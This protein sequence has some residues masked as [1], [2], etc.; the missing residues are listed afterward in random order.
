MK[1][2]LTELVFILD[3]SGSMQGL[4]VDTIGGFNA[5][6]EKQKKEP[7]EAFVST[8]LFNDH[9]QV[10][11]DR[12]KIEAVEPITHRE[13]YVRGC[14]ALLDAI[15]GAIHH[16]GNIHKYARS[17]DVPEHTLFVITTD[18]MENAS[19]RYTSQ[20]VKT[21]IQ[22]QKEKYGW[23]FLFLGAN[24]DA[25]ETAGSLGIAPDRAVNYHCDSEGTRLN[26]EVVSQAVTAV[27][28]CA[29]LDE[30]WKDDIEEDFRKRKSNRR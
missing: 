7:G 25:V 24:I 9:T 21:M 23:E 16:I 15:G 8:I 18:G 22:R 11:H 27:R 2:N 13:Y 29:T 12:V 5:M 17:E 10:L 14:T 28:C 26:Y 6:L 20:Q 4:E 30:H 3:R 1:K 19:R